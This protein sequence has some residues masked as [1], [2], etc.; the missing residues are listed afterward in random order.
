MKNSKINKNRN[1]FTEQEI[2]ADE[3]FDSLLKKASV[4]GGNNKLVVGGVVIGLI[5]VAGLFWLFN[6]KKGQQSLAENTEISNQQKGALSPVLG[7]IPKSYYTVNAEK[8]EDF[9]FNN[10]VISIPTHA[11]IDKNGNIVT[12]EVEISYREFHN[13]IDFFLSGIPMTYDSAGVEYHF[14]SAGMF[15]I[16][17]YQ[18]GEPVKLVK[19]IEVRLASLHQGDYFNIYQ[20]DTLSGEWTY[21][22]KDTSVVKRSI[23]VI[24]QELTD[25]NKGI[26]EL[27]NKLPSKKSKNGVCI[28]IDFNAAE[29]PEL[30]SLKEVLFEVDAT[31]KNFSPN[32]AQ[33]DWDDVKLKK[34]DD[35][36]VLIFYDKFKPTKIKAKPVL[37]DGDY[38]KV[39]KE[40]E[41]KINELKSQSKASKKNN[42][43]YIEVELLSGEAFYIGE[44]EIDEKAERD[45]NAEYKVER[46]FMINDFGIFNSDCPMRLP[47]GKIV[48]PLF[49]YK[50]DSTNSIDG[51][52]FNGVYLVEENK[53]TLYYLYNYD[54][55]SYI[56]Q[57]KYVI[58]GI[59]DGKL[60]VLSAKEFKQ[61]TFKGKGAYKT[62]MKMLNEEITSVEQV[63][64]FL[65]LQ[66][67][68]K[69]V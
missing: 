4:K 31:D 41:E 47:K 27:K 32:L 49:V 26:S 39:M 58:W 46:L 65:D 20:L 33:K 43:V 2:A 35:E 44:S 10:T 34:V 66:I 29:F 37:N 56:P 7:D 30:A 11:F 48:E 9:S 17:G 69:D 38:L 68:F 55:I 3:N 61:L 8:G 15:E 1:H 45:Y 54:L 36:Y 64:E 42:K 13:P 23:G 51:L 5:L 24:P 12:G 21:L 50:N 25:L 52:K 59:Y 62:E 63:R 40:Y 6:T 18:N 16:Y 22:S 60:C 28:K 67:L 19:P 57:N 14:E 53:N